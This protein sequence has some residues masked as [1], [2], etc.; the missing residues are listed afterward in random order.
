MTRA[1]AAETGRY[2]YT[3]QDAIRFRTK[4]VR[5]ARDIILT[6]SSIFEELR[7]DLSYYENDYMT[8]RRLQAQK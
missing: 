1:F 7:D 2:A 4:P 8:Q 6:V 5:A 3:G